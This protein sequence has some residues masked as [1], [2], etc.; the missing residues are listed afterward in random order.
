MNAAIAD[1]EHEPE[2]GVKQTCSPSEPVSEAAAQG[3]LEPAPEVLELL[4]KMSCH[5]GQAA[6][7]VLGNKI[8]AT[9]YWSC[10]LDVYNAANFNS[11]PPIAMYDIHHPT[12]IAASERDR[13]L[14]VGDMWSSWVHAIGPDD[15]RRTHWNPGGPFIGISVACGGSNVVVA[16]SE[17]QLLTEFSPFGRVIRHIR[18][19][20]RLT[21]LELL[22]APLLIKPIHAIS[23][24][25][26]R[27]VLCQV[28]RI[29]VVDDTGKVQ[30]SCP[31]PMSKRALGQFDPVHVALDSS[32]RLFVVDCSNNRIVILTLALDLIR[33]FS[34]APQGLRQPLSLAIDE[35]H[36]QL[37]VASA[38]GQ[39]FVY[40][41][42]FSA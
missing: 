4:F 21:R 17:Q 12:C 7:V 35:K 33:T 27:M 19:A 9:H 18:L 1:E 20:S 37:C 22:R 31:G 11:L 3:L 30:C 42:D 13:L 36:G 32:G 8:Y 29:C 14:F 5:D 41:F 34:T 16:F 6:V 15:N 28:G 38:I 10:T 26:E 2:P 39:A 24:S 40:G 23:L 25:D